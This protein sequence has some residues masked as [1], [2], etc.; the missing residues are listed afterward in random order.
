MNSIIVS[1]SMQW[2]LEKE[3]EKNK[4]ETNLRIVI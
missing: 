3:T 2:I 1:P 4:T